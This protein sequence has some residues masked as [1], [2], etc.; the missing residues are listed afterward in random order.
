MIISRTPVRLSFFGGGTDYPTYFRRKRGAVLGTT[1]DKYIYVT[2]NQG[3]PFFEHKIRVS[4]SK[5]ELVNRVEDIQHPSVR[6]TL[7]FLEMDGHLDI[8]IFADLPA[9]TGLGSSSTFTVGFLNACYAYRG[10][11]ANKARLANEAIHI[12]QDRLQ[13]NVGIQDQTHAAHGGLNIIRM[14]GDGIA[15]TPVVIKQENKA[16]LEESLMLFYTGITR[17][18]SELVKEQIENT[19]SLAIDDYLER[20]VDQVDEGQQILS[21]Y[22]GDEMLEKFGKLLHEGW[23]LKKRLSR[24]IS[25]TQIDGYYQMALKAGAI[26]GKVGGA[27]GGGFLMLVVKPEKQAEVRKVLKDLLEV[28]FGFDSNGASIIYSYEP[29]QYRGAMKPALLGEKI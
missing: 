20:M 14:D 17:F 4:Y 23:E 5:A 1:I 16:Y 24:Q 21:T 2:I 29:P 18:A 6:E 27:G 11:F 7:K 12:E 9:K 19:A 15:V 3:S 26:G 25:T 13:E 8:H 28:Q 10:V 22:S